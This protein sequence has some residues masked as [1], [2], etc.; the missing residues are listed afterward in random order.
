MVGGDWPSPGPPWCE[1]DVRAAIYPGTTADEARAEIDA[2]LRD[3]VSD[4]RLGGT[5]PQVPYTGFYADGY[6]LDEGSDA[7]NTLRYCHPQAFQR[8]LDTFTTTGHRDARLLLIH[9]ELPTIVYG[10]PSQL[11]PRFDA[12]R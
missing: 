9:G 7:E 11:I 1:F 12:P 6:V 4:P 3:A 8:A 5:P 10:P 2:C